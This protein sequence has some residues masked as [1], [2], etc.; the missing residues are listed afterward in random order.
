[1]GPGIFTGVGVALVTLFDEQ[2]GLDATGTADHARRLVE[3]GVQAV[4]VAGTTGEAAGLEPGERA[5]LVEAV[6]GRVA[7]EVPVLV[8]TGAPSVRQ[9]V[10]L[11]QDAVAAGADA[12]LVLSPPLAVDPAPY[13]TAVTRSVHVPVLA[14]HFPRVSAPGIAVERLPELPVAGLKDSSED[15][16][17]LLAELEVFDRPLYTGSAALLTM[18]GAIGAAGAILALANVEPE[19]CAA[20]FAGDGDAQRRLTT[21]H[22]A[23]QH[24]FPSGLKELLADRSGTSPVTRLG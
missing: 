10:T 21:A 4:V 3:R 1:M 20:A 2:G 19:R 12:L 9:A 5:E 17:R 7:E 16:T 24:R 6:R 13:Y 18:A 8:G 14:Y 15:P 22:L 11:S 23:S